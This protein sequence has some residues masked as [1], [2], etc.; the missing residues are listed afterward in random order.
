MTS[1]YRYGL[2]NLPWSL[3]AQLLNPYGG[4]VGY[5]TNDLLSASVARV[6]LYGTDGVFAGF[7]SGGSLGISIGSNPGNFPYGL[8]VEPAYGV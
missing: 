7:G 2:L 8:P 5:L 1:K 6:V 3:N 4:L